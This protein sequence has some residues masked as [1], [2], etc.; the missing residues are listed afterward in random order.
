MLLKNFKFKEVDLY[1]IIIIKN[2]FTN[3]PIIQLFVAIS[4]AVTTIII[5]IYSKLN[6]IAIKVL[7]M[8]NTI[9]IKINNFKA[10]HKFN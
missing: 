6:I 2:N 8:A 7:F 10:M 1:I 5:A 3:F 9:I 4:A